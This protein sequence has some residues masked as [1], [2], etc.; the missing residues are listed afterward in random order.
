MQ[1]SSFPSPS[2]TAGA[3]SLDRFVAP[4]LAM[5]KR[6][7]ATSPPSLRGTKQSSAAATTTC[8]EAGTGVCAACSNAT[9]ADRLDCFV[10]PPRNDGGGDNDGGGCHNL[11]IRHCEARSNPVPLQSHCARIWAQAFVPPVPAPCL[12]QDWIASSFLLAMTAEGAMMVEGGTISPF[13][14]ARHEAIHCRCN[15]HRAVGGHRLSCNLFKRST[16]G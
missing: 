14:I 11:S 6:G 16:C 4:L 15:P 5:T 1:K 13:V 9:P 8:G 3:D 12:W 7:G 10:V 2:T